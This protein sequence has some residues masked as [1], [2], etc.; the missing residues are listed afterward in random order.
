MTE[1]GHLL[2]TFA[3]GEVLKQASW[4]D[5]VAG[6]GHWRTHDGDEVDLV[7]ERYDGRVI[8]FEVKAAGRAGAEHLRSLRKLR[9][10]VGD[11]FAAGALLYLGERGY[12]A[13]DR[14]H[15]LPL[16]ALWRPAP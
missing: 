6:A 14:L 15:V 4:L 11:R 9:D 1:F 16:D 8:A 13:D 7:V 5:D 10:A 3:V 12:T 2:E